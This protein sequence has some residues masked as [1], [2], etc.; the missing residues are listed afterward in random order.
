MSLPAWPARNEADNRRMLQWL[1]WRL[2]EINGKKLSALLKPKP[3][4]TEPE[5]LAYAINLPKLKKGACWSRGKKGGSYIARAAADVSLIRK[6]WLEHYGKKR[7]RQ[8]DGWPAERFAAEIWEVDAD[9]IAR[10]LKH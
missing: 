6:I 10:Y 2:A 7:R 4:T 1:E 8:S 9:Q 5:R 3:P